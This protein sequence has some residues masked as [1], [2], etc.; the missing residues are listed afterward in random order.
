VSPVERI[1]GPFLLGHEDLTGALVERREIATTAARSNGVL[2]HAPEA[3]D[4]IEMVTPMGR[5]EME[6]QRV[7]VVRKG[8]VKLVRSVAPAALGAHHDL[9]AGGAEGGHPWVAILAELLGIKVRHDCREACGGA[10]LDRAQPTEQ[11]A[12]RDPA[13]GAMAYPRLAF[14]GCVALARARAQRTGGQTRALRTAPPAQPGEGKAPQDSCIF[15]EQNDLAAA[16]SILPGSEG[17]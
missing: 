2:H 4:R 8:R 13:P 16:R 5:E 9:L 17:D 7:V 10:V 11:H 12:A 3:F 14:A 6:A 15:I 1:D